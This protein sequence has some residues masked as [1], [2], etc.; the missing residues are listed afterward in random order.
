MTFDDPDED[1]AQ[2][3]PVVDPALVDTVLAKRGRSPTAWRVASEAEL[4][5]TMQAF[6]R[7]LMRKSDA[8]QQLIQGYGSVSELFKLGRKVEQLLRRLDDI[9]NRHPQW[10]LGE[11]RQKCPLPQERLIVVA[12]LGK[13]LGHLPAG[14]PLFTGGG[15]CE[16]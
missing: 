6:T 9:L 15:L 11:I 14:E 2:R 8:V 7:T 1:L 4:L 3:K 16:P 5:D 13:R 12:L 10:K